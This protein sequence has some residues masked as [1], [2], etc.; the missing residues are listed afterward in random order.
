MDQVLITLEHPEHNQPIDSLHDDAPT[1]QHHSHSLTH[2]DYPWQECNGKSFHNEVDE[3]A[4]ID[5][6]P[7]HQGQEL[8]SDTA[9]SEYVRLTLQL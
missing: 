7:A 9:A 5:Y 8:A 3:Y 2:I 6:S 4:Q 1:E